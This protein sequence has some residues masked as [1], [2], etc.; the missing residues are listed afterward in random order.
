MNQPIGYMLGGALAPRRYYGRR[1][2][3]VYYP[4]A[5]TDS[6]TGRYYEKGYYDEEGKYYSDVSFQKDGKYSNVIC[7]CPYCGNE[8]IINLDN[9][10][11]TTQDLQ[12]PNCTGQMEIKSELD[13]VLNE[14]EA[15]S[16]YR[17]RDN[18]VSELVQEEQKKK[19]KNTVIIIVAILALLLVRGSVRNALRK[20]IE[21]VVQPTIQAVQTIDN[22]IASNTN[23]N[24][25]LQLINGVQII[26][27]RPVYLELNSD[28]GYHA[29]NDPIRADKIMPWNSDYE[30]WYDSGT[31]CYVWY[32]TDVSPRVWQYWYEGISSDYG[33]YG[34]MEHDSD[35]WWIEASQN[36]WIK[37]PSRYN[38]SNLWYISG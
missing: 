37:L 35:G 28:G 26:E 11:G 14:S 30:S 13:E 27:G 38:T 34:W 16:Y 12:C 10:T 9:M 29:V 2:D 17:T 5:W 1:H 3:Y 31:D 8:T 22:N 25:E 7:Q 33:D 18:D 36:N 19:H 21:P 20:K 6:S 15:D 24:D 4:S 23:D 32:N